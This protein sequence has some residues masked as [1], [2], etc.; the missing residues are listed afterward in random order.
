ML[1]VGPGQARAAAASSRLTSRILSSAR[2]SAIHRLASGAVRAAVRATSPTPQRGVV[3]DARRA[4]GNTLTVRL[5][6]NLDLSVN[7]HV[8]LNP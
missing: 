2:P 6:F 7:Q 1:A 4:I 5:S 8:Q 3:G